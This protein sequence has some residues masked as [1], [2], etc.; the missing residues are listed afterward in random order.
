MHQMLLPA[1]NNS[2]LGGFVDRLT[3][4]SIFIASTMPSL[5]PVDVPLE[6]LRNYKIHELDHT[7]GSA[8]GAAAW[9]HQD[10]S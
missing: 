4:I 10:P 6:A 8:A 7:A 1:E 9:A 5:V 3:S 2:K